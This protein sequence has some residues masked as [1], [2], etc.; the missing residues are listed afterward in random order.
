MDKLVHF[1]VGLI[2]SCGI[3][4]ISI[5]ILKVWAIEVYFIW[6]ILIACCFTRICKDLN[7]NWKFKKK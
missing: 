4:L 5:S 2:I 1:I 7:L 6:C 3:A